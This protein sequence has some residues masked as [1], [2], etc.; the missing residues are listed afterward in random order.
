[1]HYA[2]SYFSF[3]DHMFLAI[4]DC[5]DSATPFN[6]TGSQHINYYD[7]CRNFIYRGE[8]TPQLEGTMQVVI[9][10]GYN[11]FSSLSQSNALPQERIYK[12]Y[13]CLNFD[14]K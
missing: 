8:L 3:S 11:M 13:Q 7:Q 9:M 5:S 1:M 2:N 12:F 10:H 4:I 14:Y 6:L